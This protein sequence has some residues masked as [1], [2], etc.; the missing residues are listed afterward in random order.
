MP[1]CVR[2]K[3]TAEQAHWRMAHP[4][5]CKK[6]ATPHRFASQ[7]MLDT[8]NFKL[9]GGPPANETGFCVGDGI[10]IVSGKY[11]NMDGV[12]VKSISKSTCRLLL[13][14]G[15]STGNIHYYYIRPKVELID[16]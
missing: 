16:V 15:S 5:L 6:C 13:P 2:W 7:L 3:S 11:A 9:H 10:E 14:D 4:F 8:H 12:T 1:K